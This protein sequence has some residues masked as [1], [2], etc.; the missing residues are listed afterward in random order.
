MTRNLKNFVNYNL[1]STFSS[2]Y[3]GLK[4][5]SSRINLVSVLISIVTTVFW[6]KV[7][8]TQRQSF[9]TFFYIQECPDIWLHLTSEH[10]R[11]GKYY[12]IK[13]GTN[14]WWIIG[15]SR[16]RR[17]IERWEWRW[18]LKPKGQTSKLQ[19][20]RWPSGQLLQ[21]KKSHQRVKLSLIGI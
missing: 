17:A 4:E 16:R 8:V 9:A 15:C 21:V 19:P 10:Q 13:I 18:R 14:N 7:N 11:V 20:S 1:L 6:L 12:I 2:F 5:T 3:N